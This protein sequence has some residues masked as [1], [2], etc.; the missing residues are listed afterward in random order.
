[1]LGRTLSHYLIESLLG[2][3]GMGAV[4]LARDLALGR[5]A[6][7]KVVANSLDSEFRDRLLLEAEAAA[8]LQHPA[9]ATFYESGVVQEEAFIAMEHVRGRTLRDLLAGGPLPVA[10]V[11]TVGSALLE[12]LNHAHAAGILH[13]DIKP[14]NIMVTEAGAPKLLDFGLAK[15]FA[16]ASQVDDATV[17]NLTGER[18]LGTVGYMSPEQLRGEALGPS[19]DLFAVGAVLYELASGRPAFPGA[20]PTERIAAILSQDP[21]PLEGAAFPPALWPIVQRALAKDRK[22]RYESASAMLS[23]LRAL[24]EGA[25]LA[26]PLP[27]SLVVIDFRNLSR[28]PDDD[29]IGSGIAESVSAD[30]ARAPGLTL[31]GREKMLATLRSTVGATDSTAD[32]LAL[33]SILGCRW[34]LLGSFQRLGTALRLTSQLTEVA[35]GDVIAAEKLDGPV[36]ALFGMQDRLA[37]AVLQSLHLNVP[38]AA[39]VIQRRDVHA[40]ECYARGRRL[41]QRLQKGTFDQARELYEKA[42]EQEPGHAQALA[43]L[44]ALHAMRFTFTTDPAELERASSYARRSIASDPSLGDPHVWLGYALM[45]QNRMDEALAAELRAAELD[46]ANGYPPYF[47]GCVEQFRGRAAESIP[48]FQR[49]VKREPPHGFAWLALASAHQSLGNLKECQWCIERAIALETVPGAAPTAGASGFLGDCLRLQGHLPE[50][51]VAC[52]AGID[53]AERSDHMYRDTFRAVSLCCLGRT[54]LD[55][56]D[57]PAAHAALTQ[58]VAHVRG[59]E[60]TLGGGF[61]LIQAFAGL[62][63][64][65]DGEESLTQAIR[66]FE[67]RNRYNF[68]LLWTC[69]DETTLVELA[70]ASAALGFPWTGRLREA[71]RQGSYEAGILLAKGLAT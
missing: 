17:A 12:A 41:W 16:A 19:S 3:G 10:T 38:T 58:A 65:G 60:R 6:A 39:A 66:L 55:Q 7:L 51:R 68:S 45:R 8:R 35:T 43:G 5:T 1:V 69:N 48:Y 57:I 31:V 50:A 34:I 36:D 9:I 62:A 22:G 64:C 20:R 59:R 24:D 63:R 18:I 26:S 40:F 14:E 53:A 46:P 11:I 23:D 42:I 70:R 54:A 30:L 21:I 49:A 33:G 37:R 52:L 2:E 71:Q 29:W 32:A 56:G 28:Q 44:A 47:A 15:A 4:Y 61:L 13:R 67:A 27:Q 25:T